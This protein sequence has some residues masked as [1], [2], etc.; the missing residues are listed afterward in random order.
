MIGPN[1]LECLHL[2]Y[3]SSLVLCNTPAYL[4]H[5]NCCVQTVQGANPNQL[6]LEITYSFCELDHFIIIH[7]FF[8]SIKRS[9][10]QKEGVNLLQFFIGLAPWPNVLKL[11]MVVI[12]ECA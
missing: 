5:S 11:F 12:Y 3:L 7:N 8:M 9:S 10:F 4:A 2:A 6:Y 1:K